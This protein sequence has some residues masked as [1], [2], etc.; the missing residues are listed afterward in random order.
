MHVHCIYIKLLFALKAPLYNECGYFYQCNC[1]RAFSCY[2]D[3]GL[4]KQGGKCP[5]L[6]FSMSYFYINILNPFKVSCTCFYQLFFI[7]FFCI[8]SCFLSGFEYIFFLLLVKSCLKGL[9]FQY[10]L[11]LLKE[12]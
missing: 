12:F 4:F 1:F 10:L 8:D 11:S 9:S 3:Y 5:F 2:C 6:R 7:S